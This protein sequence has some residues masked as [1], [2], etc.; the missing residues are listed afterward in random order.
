[1]PALG[2]V[3]PQ[4]IKEER[5]SQRSTPELSPLTSV[6]KSRMSDTM[7]ASPT[8]KDEPL[9]LQLSSSSIRPKNGELQPKT[10]T[11][12]SYLKT[13]ISKTQLHV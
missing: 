10:V 11:Q 13:T 12:I 7:M 6:I 9:N 8:A 1:M 5:V 4:Q 2:P 3:F